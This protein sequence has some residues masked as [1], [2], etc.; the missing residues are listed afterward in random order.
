MGK[1]VGIVRCSWQ[2]ETVWRY[3][4]MRGRHTNIITCLPVSS[5]EPREALGNS[6]GSCLLHIYPRKYD[7]TGIMETPQA[8][9]EFVF[10]SIQV[11][12]VQWAQPYSSTPWAHCQGS[13]GASITLSRPSYIGISSLLSLPLP[14]PHGE[15]TWGFL[16]QLVETGIG[17]R[18]LLTPSP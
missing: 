14:H 4:G 7:C 18:V 5:S 6:L 13:W 17:P 15:E 8:L 1:E 2:M 3:P 12:E 10:L 9:F 11:K 16:H